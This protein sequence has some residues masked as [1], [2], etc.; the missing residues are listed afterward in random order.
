MAL[1]ATLGA[2]TQNSYVTVDEADTYFEDRPYST[3]WDTYSEADKPKLLILCSSLLDW[4]IKWKGYKT[5]SDQPMEWPRSDVVLK[6]GTELDDDVLPVAVKK[7]VYELA[8]STLE[9]GKDRTLDDD[10]LG[11]E[12]LKVASLSLR[13]KPDKWGKRTTATEVIPEKVYQILTDLRSSSA[14]GSVRLIRG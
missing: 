14:F 4:Y 3:K 10:L 1:D 6:D 11:L 5:D 8:L 9:K 7:A 13:A 12:Q 2:S